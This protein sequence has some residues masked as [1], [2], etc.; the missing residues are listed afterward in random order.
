MWG[1]KQPHTFFENRFGK[2]HYSKTTTTF[3]KLEVFVFVF[4]R[5]AVRNTIY[6]FLWSQ[7]YRGRLR[8]SL[9]EKQRGDAPLQYKGGS[10]NLSF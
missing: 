10:A 3:I 7:T 1:H 6:R 8:V 5:N 2:N 4:L 9:P